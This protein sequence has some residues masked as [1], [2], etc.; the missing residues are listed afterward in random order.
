MTQSNQ[1]TALTIVEPGQ[2]RSGELGGVG[3]V[4]SCGARTRTAMSRWWNIRSLLE[5]L[6]SRIGT[7]VRTSIRLLQRVPSDF[8]SKIAKLS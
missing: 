7:P 3:V 2:G 8:G 6:G 4:F 1:A 5:R